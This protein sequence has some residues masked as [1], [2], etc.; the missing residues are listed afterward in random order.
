M[1]TD[2]NQGSQVSTLVLI[3]FLP[4]YH[5]KYYCGENPRD[6][7]P[8]PHPKVWA[9]TGALAKLISFNPYF[10]GFDQDDKTAHSPIGLRG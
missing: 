2:K 3:A 4:M 5:C 6:F 9:K 10:R 8:P 1:K 7:F